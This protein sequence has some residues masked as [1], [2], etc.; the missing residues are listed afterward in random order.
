MIWT[1]LFRERANVAGGRDARH[2]PPRTRRYTDGQRH[3]LHAEVEILF[4]CLA[5]R[6]VERVGIC[7]TQCKLARLRVLNPEVLPVEKRGEALDAV[8]LVDALPPRLLGEREHVVGK[9]VHGVLDGLR[10]TVDDVDSLVLRAL[11]EVL[12][13]AAEAGQ[14]RRR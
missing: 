2:S 14:V 5:A 8:P 9:L 11:D 1:Y 6:A 12:D 4:L 3:T 7:A 13:E 10:A